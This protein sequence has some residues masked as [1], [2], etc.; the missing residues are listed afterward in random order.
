MPPPA[1][2]KLAYHTLLPLFSV[3]LPFSSHPSD[4]FAR[5]LA[6]SNPP[7]P[8]APKHATENPTGQVP[9]YAP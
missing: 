1:L 5:L 2:L 6:F 4:P 8:V 3:P 7:S 9:G